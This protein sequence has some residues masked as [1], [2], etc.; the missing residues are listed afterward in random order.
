M[1]K[2]SCNRYT[3]KVFIYGIEPEIWRRFSIDGSATFAQLHKALQDALGWEDRQDH[4]FR[5]GKGKQ[6]NDVIAA[7]DHDHAGQPYFQDETKLTIDEF[8]GRKHVPLRM[9]YRYD[10]MEDWVHELV[11][12]AKEE[13]DTAAAPAMVDGAR[14]CPPEDSGGTYEY[15]A[16]LS[17]ES[18]WLDIDYDP[19]KFD[20]DAVKFRK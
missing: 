14:A 20:A 10:F 16:C 13:V 4:E 8:V 5:H 17:G 6:L 3:I 11:I 12:E 19:E 7:T 2:S 15:M 18:D 9:L 1:P